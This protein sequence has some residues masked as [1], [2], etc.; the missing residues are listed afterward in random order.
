MAAEGEFPKVNGDVLYASEVNQ[1]G[2]ET[3]IPIGIKTFASTNASYIDVTDWANITIDGSKFSYATVTLI[4]D[5]K[6]NGLFNAQ[7]YNVS[8]SVAVT[9][10]EIV[11]T[12]TTIA[13]IESSALTL[14]ASSKIYKVQI[15]ESGGG[16]TGTIESAW[17]KI[18]FS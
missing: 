14:P 3:Y 16:T 12:G 15:K 5:I 18:V 17:L 8:D 1:L 11:S 4:A 10:S 13:R 6:S 7:L 2:K 9:D